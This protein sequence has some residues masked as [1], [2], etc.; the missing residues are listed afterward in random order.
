MNAI[1]EFWQARTSRE[2]LLLALLGV[3]LAAAV[4]FLAL[5]DPL[6]RRAD[7]FEQKL[8]AEQILLQTVDVTGARLRV[9]PPQRPRSD[10]S[11]LLSVSR[12][13][14]EAGLSSY[15]EESNAD[16][17]RRVRLS[18]RDAPFPAVGGW[19][20]D[21]AMRENVHTVSADI[22][23]GAST[24]RTQITLVLERRD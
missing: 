6:A 14:Q 10:S 16:G 18:F 12:G 1:A 22:E 7:S 21:L 3:A 4:W 23:R 20:A 15:L 24:G 17:E 13:L 2:R 11:L 8:A 9:L 19:L 5:V